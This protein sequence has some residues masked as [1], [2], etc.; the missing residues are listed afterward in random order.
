MKFMKVLS[1]EADLM[2]SHLALLRKERTGL[3]SEGQAVV[4]TCWLGKKY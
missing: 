2:L 3:A 1:A 4:S